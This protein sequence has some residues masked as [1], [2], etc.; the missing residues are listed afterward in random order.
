MTELMK[1]KYYNYDTL[2]DLASR[3]KNVYPQFQKSD[4]IN[5]IMDNDWEMLELKARM[6]KITIHLGN[7]LPCKY[8]EALAI[9]D[10]VVASYPAG[11]NDNAL[12]YFPDFVEVY[13]QDEQDWDLSI[14]ALEKYTQLSTAEFAVRPLIIKHEVRMMQQMA[15]W[16]NHENE[17]V[18]RLAS[19]GCRPALPW[20]QAL[21][22]FKKDP[23][24]VLAILEKMKADPSLYVRKSVANNLNDISKTHPDLV[25]NIAK[26]WY[27][28]DKH[29]DWIV[30][31]GCRTLLKKGN[32]DVLAIFGYHDAS[33]VDIKDFSLTAESLN[34][35]ESLTFSFT[36][37]AK[38]TTKLRLE[39]GIDYVKA[40]GKR[41]RK[42]FQLSDTVLK[43]NQ[44]KTYTKKHSFADLSSRKHYPGL[45]SVTLIVNG[46]ERETLDFEL[47][48]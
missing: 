29:T 7:Y 33:S 6:R 15:V 4:F 22:S 21:T 11:H 34:Y 3:I 28:K 13:G 40:N 18:R 38:E 24:P 5:D 10:Q 45:H 35:G 47:T 20:G 46:A 41:S 9:L 39:Y 43:A 32:R 2:Y 48:K 8:I 14:A 19:E 36:I 30:K 1:D 44:S 12:I 23:S 37:S 42:I 25:A 17:H 26:D 16:A 31:H 27:G